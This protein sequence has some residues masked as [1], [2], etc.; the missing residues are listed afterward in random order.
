L[1]RH[2]GDVTL[3]L[4]SIPLSENKDV[5]R[6][7]QK[8]DGLIA[9]GEIKHYKAYDRT[10]TKVKLLAEDEEWEEEDE[11]G[12]AGEMEE[13][14]EEEEEV[15]EEESKSNGAKQKGGNKKM[16]KDKFSDLSAMILAKKGNEH[17]SFLDDLERKY[18]GGG[19]KGKGKGS[20]SNGKGAKKG[21][22]YE[23]DDEEFEKIQK[24]MF[25]EGT[26][27]TKK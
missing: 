13:E 20:T 14:E 21:T 16:K 7:L 5:E 6:F 23:I 8:L 1:F 12:N 24:R 26:K 3:L 25:G 27:K 15:V 11:E 19:A 22:E 10:R 17:L 18:G 9:G 2:K 4:E